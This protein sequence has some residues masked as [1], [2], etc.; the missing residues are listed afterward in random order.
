MKRMIFLPAIGKHIPLGI[1][2]DGIRKAKANPETE[3]KHGL[4]SWW[5]TTG[6]EIM[7]QFRREIDDRINKAV[8][9]NIRGRRSL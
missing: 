1:Y 5:P 2:L 4:G 9:Y 3:F 6:A 7:R 8:P